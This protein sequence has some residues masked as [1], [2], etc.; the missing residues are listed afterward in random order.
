MNVFS[1]RVTGCSLQSFP[2]KKQEKDFHCHPARGIRFQMKIAFTSPF[3]C[4]KV[5]IRSLKTGGN[6]EGDSVKKMLM[7]PVS[8]HIE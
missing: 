3:R 5:I 7:E 8:S 6:N 1:G 4:G 2:A